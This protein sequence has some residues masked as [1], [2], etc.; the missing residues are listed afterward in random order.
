MYK[1]YG[2][3]LIIPKLT[4]D[5]I[6][7]NSSPFCGVNVRN[8]GLH[9]RNFLVFKRIFDRANSTTSAVAQESN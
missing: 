8:V 2:D 6:N 9:Y 4:L 5:Y 1:C 3:P 7:P